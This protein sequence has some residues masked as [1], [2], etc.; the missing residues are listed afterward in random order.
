M[1]EVT[2]LGLAELRD[3]LQQELPEEIQTKALQSSLAKAA[4]PIVKE[5]RN[6]VPV[7][8]GAVRRAIT[9]GKSRKSTKQKAVRIIGVNTKRINRPPTLNGRSRWADR[10]YWKQLEFGR[11]AYTS[12]RN[13]GTPD[14]GF[15]GRQF[16]AV[17]AR[18]FLRPAFESRKHE[19][20]ETFRKV[21][22]GEINKTAARLHRQNLTKFRRRVLGV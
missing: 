19:A 4:R 1:E 14:R 13:L 21:M 17:P 15:F 2:V 10:Y 18:P 22:A 16:R 5:A 11:A 6:R 12:K 3:L 20:L 9:S 7:K 8:T